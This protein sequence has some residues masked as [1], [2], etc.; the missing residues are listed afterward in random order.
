[1]SEM[2]PPTP[3]PRPL[4]ERHPILVNTL[5][6]VA[7]LVVVGGAIAFLV[8]TSNSY[9]EP[10]TKTTP[11]ESAEFIWDEEVDELQLCR[12]Y[13]ELPYA[14]VYEE[15]FLVRASGMDDPEAV[16]EEMLNIAARECPEP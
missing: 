10:D 1:M 3:E 5:I 8:L 13:W 4:R 16:A 12:L 7:G 14:D 11:R 6:F 2:P 15:V 9:S